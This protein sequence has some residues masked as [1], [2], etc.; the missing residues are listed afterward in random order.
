MMFKID[1]HNKIK[2]DLSIISDNYEVLHFDEF[3]ILFTG[4]NIYGNT[5]VGSL[6][7]DNEDDVFRYFHV[8]VSLKDFAE[9]KNQTKSYLDLLKI[10]QSVFV[11]D[12]DIN[13]N[14]KNTYLLP[15]NKIPKDYLPLPTA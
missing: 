5:I 13:G 1:I 15:L 4:T 6:A 11:L 12:K 3:P 7:C 14:V 9:F 8:I 10:A 2:T